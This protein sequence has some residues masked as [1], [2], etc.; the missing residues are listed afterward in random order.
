MGWS[1]WSN[2]N[3]NGQVI[4]GSPLAPNITSLTNGADPTIISI[5]WTGLST[6]PLNGFSAVTGYKVYSNGG[7]GDNFSNLVASTASGIT[8]A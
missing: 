1:Q 5:T 3:I 2:P 4:Q 8:S 6:T 7:S